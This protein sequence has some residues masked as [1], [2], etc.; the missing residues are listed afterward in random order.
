MNMLKSLFGDLTPIRDSTSRTGGKEA[1]ADV[2]MPEFASTAVMAD[3][4]ELAEAAAEAEARGQDGETIDA[5]LP[6]NTPLP[7]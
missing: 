4:N 3:E 7:K 2:E 6:V 1:S 5:G